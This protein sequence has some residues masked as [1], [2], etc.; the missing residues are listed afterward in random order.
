MQPRIEIGIE[1]VEEHEET[2]GREGW[3]GGKEGSGSKS[4]VAGR[5]ARVE[6]SITKT[7]LMPATLLLFG[8]GRSRCSQGARS[9]L[10]AAAHRDVHCSAVHIE[11]CSGPLS[12]TGWMHQLLVRV[13]RRFEPLREPIEPT[14]PMSQEEA[15]RERERKGK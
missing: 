4:R 8:P 13:R 15:E 11:R 14:S 5:A 2:E 3:R 10:A 9:E 12:V 7:R 1:R 6:S